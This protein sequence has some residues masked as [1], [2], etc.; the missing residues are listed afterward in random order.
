MKGND[1][2]VIFL[3]STFVKCKKSYEV[4]MNASVFR[5][6]RACVSVMF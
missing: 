2:D 3:P 5:D 1:E 4:S 6:L